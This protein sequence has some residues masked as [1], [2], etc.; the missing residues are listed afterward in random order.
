[1]APGDGAHQR[2]ARR[3]RDPLRG[4]LRLHLSRNEC[5]EALVFLSSR[6][7]KTIPIGVWE[8]P[9]TRA[10]RAL[11]ADVLRPHGR[12]ALDELGHQLLATGIVEHIYLDPA[13]AQ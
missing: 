6:Q 13:A 1:M 8:P 4:D 11:F 2:P 9:T 7:Q 5:L 10:L 3:S 12:M